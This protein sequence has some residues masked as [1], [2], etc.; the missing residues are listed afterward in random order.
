MPVL[1]RLGIAMH[2]I[3]MRVRAAVPCLRGQRSRT[4]NDHSRTAAYLDSCPDTPLCSWWCWSRRSESRD[5]SHL[6]VHTPPQVCSWASHHNI[7][8]QENNRHN[9]HRQHNNH[10]NSL[11]CMHIPHCYCPCCFCWLPWWQ[12]S[13]ALLGAA[14]QQASNMKSLSSRRSLTSWESETILKYWVISE[15]IFGFKTVSVWGWLW[16]LVWRPVIRSVW[17][18]GRYL[19]IYGWDTPPVKLKVIRD[20]GNGLYISQLG[21]NLSLVSLCSAGKLSFQVFPFQTDAN[22]RWAPHKKQCWLQHHYLMVKD[23]HHK[24]VAEIWKFPNVDIAYTTPA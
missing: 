16:V 13:V 17:K 23:K 22:K 14:S 3:D 9:S 19:I 12:G 2:L 10:R 15:G 20:S 5:N 1:Y 18:R 4:A 24:G 6:P 21:E 8:R 7:H 11:R